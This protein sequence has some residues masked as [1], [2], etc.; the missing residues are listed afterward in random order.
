M[1]QLCSHL[2]NC[3]CV[4]AA[5]P[6]DSFDEQ[7][8]VFVDSWTALPVKATQVLRPLKLKPSETISEGAKLLW[9]SEEDHFGDSTSCKSYLCFSYT[10]LKNFINVFSAHYC[11][12]TS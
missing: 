10:L 6:M 9:P 8:A 11:C 3:T 5:F 4:H 12:Y 1:V 7:F 2:E